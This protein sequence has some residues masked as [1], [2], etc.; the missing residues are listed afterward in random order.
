MDQFYD[1]I[2]P[3]LSIKPLLAL[4]LATSLGV[5]IGALPGL[6]TT[7]GVALLVGVASAL[8]MTYTFVTLLGVFVGGVYG[9]SISAILLNIPGT[10]SAAA[11]ALD[12]YPFCLQGRAPFAIKVTRLSSVIGTFIGVLL[13]ALMTPLLAQMALQFTSP[14]FFALGLFGVMIC[15]SITC[16]DLTIKGWI[17]ALLGI[18]VAFVG[19][20][21]V[22]GAQRYTAGI[23]DLMSG[24][25]IIPVMIG[26]YAIPEIVGY[27]CKITEVPPA[28]V[29][30]DF[31]SAGVV[32]RKVMRRGRL[33]IQSA[34]VGVG[35]GIL[36][37]VGED[38]SAWV[39]YDLAK[40]T[41]RE[42]EK[43][44]NGSEEGIIAPEVAN[45]AGVGGSLIPMLILGIPGSP[46]AAI[47]LGALML[48]GIKPGPMIELEHPGFILH[49]VCILFLAVLML[50]AAANIILHP[51]ML[52]LRVSRSYLIPCI[53]AFA[54][55]GAY[56]IN[57]STFDFIVVIVSGVIGFLMKLMRYSPAP[58]ALG[59]ILGKMID[60]KFRT[61]LM[62]NDG[63]FM[64][65][66]TRPIACVFLLI[67]FYLI[68]KN[69]FRL[70]KRS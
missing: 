61:T 54:C 19:L 15:G 45:N 2:L 63:S 53:A 50:W 59:M 43:F 37:G 49:M 55:I 14:E 21:D 31:S 46:P 28:R 16:P 42:P 60:V 66:F 48:H 35:L 41:S 3:L 36:P 69:V 56:A 27:Y 29:S 7:M 10:P 44:G 58:V 70:K 1:A 39:A 52:I 20:D 23:P 26:L 68:I 5:I 18:L 6:T 51:L 25:S 47:L 13:L 40:K 32:F 8:P 12:G 62:F 65:F 17:G 11:T 30:V 33:I 34:L 64:P 38:V 67:V 24:V 4:F 9:G 22:E 57:L